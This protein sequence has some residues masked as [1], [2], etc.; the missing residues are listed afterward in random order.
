MVENKAGRALLSQHFGIFYSLRDPQGRSQ[1][2]HPGLSDSASQSIYAL[3]LGF[4]V[5]VM[6]QE[7]TQA[8]LGVPKFP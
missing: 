7:S 6:S 4:S 8:G 2:S 3:H 1:D 5:V